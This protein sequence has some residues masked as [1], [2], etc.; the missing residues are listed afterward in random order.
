MLSEELNERITRVGP[1]TPG[2]EL[3]RRYWQPV[4][5]AAELAGGEPKRRLRILGEDLVVFRDGRGRYG[6]V[7]EHCAHRGTSLFYGFVEEQ[8][9]RCAYHGWLYDAAGRCLEQPL[10]PHGSTFCRRVRQPAYPVQQLA[11]LLFAY[12][13][14]APA[15]LLPRWDALVRTDGHRKLTTGDVSCNWVQTQENTVDPTHFSFLHGHMAETLDLPDPGGYTRPL[16]EYGFQPFEWGIL[17]SWSWG[18]DGRFGAERA[19]GNPLIFPNALA[20]A[21]GPSRWIN[22]RVPIDD[23]HTRIFSLEFRACEDGTVVDETDP[24]ARSVRPWRDADGEYALDSIVAQDTMAWETQ[25]P[26]VDRSREHLG[27]GDRGIVMF[28][29]L[30]L[31]EIA[32]VEEGGEPM[33]LVR[34]PKRNEMLELPTLFVEGD[35]ASATVAGERVVE[36]RPMR[37]VFDDRHTVFQVSQ[38][39]TV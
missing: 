15:P 6:L 26:I 35:P 9:I 23:T 3:L 28:R 20:H 14:P 2:G 13:G 39:G 19:G 25:G 10:E 21:V 8:G 11:G 27:A 5:I 31:R 1:G 30:L 36:A 34:D 16:L 24:P 33:G 7:A 37:S 29:Q 22:W 17:T 32:V 4:C 38:G 12:M 18:S